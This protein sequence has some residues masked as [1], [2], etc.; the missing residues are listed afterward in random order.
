MAENSDK[1]PITLVGPDD[2]EFCS[3]PAYTT[4][5]VKPSSPA[6]LLK[7]GAV[8]LISGAVLL[9]VGAIGAFYFWKGSDSHI[10][11]VHYT[12]SIN[13]KLQDGSMEID[14]GNNLETF[15]MGSGVEE[16]IEVNDFQNGITGIRFAGGEKC[17]IK[18]QMKARLPEMGTMTKQSISSELEGKIMPIKYEENSLTWVAVDQPVK[19]ISFLSSKVLELCGNLPIFW[20]KPTY[21]KEISEPSKLPVTPTIPPTSASN[22]QKE[23]KKKKKKDSSKGRWVEG[24]TSEGYHYYYDLITGASQWEKPEGFQGNLKKTAVKAIWVEGLS[25]DGYTYYYNTE[26]GESKWEKP[27]DFI[28]HTGDMLSSKV[29]EKSLGTVEESKSSESHSDSDGEK[30]AQEEVSTGKKKLIIKFKEKNKKSNKGTDIEM[31][32]EKSIPKQT[33]SGP[34]EEKPKTLKKPNPYGEWKEIKQEVK[35]H[36]EVDL[37]L[38]SPENDYVSTSEGDIGEPKVVFKEKTVTSLGVAADGVAPVF[39]KRKIENGK[40]RNLRQRGD[41]Q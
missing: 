13:G 19:D 7:V 14:T 21:P 40:S 28:P 8:V 15:K 20:L 3:P 32:K 30:E 12:M 34:N 23:K 1:V 18:A 17:Y 24:V 6:R 31:Q 26:T 41:D 2:I 4:V 36:E 38:P 22:Q 27:D 11:N 25:E 37:E 35:S 9:L 5:T 33:S 29:D 10:Y 16:A 39:K